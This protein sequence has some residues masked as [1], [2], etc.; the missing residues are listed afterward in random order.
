M[1]IEV[2]ADLFAFFNELPDSIHNRKHYLILPFEL[3]IHV[4]SS[5]ASSVVPADH[6]VDIHHWDY[7]HNGF[8]A[9]IECR[10]M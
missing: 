6:A 4:A 7:F 10:G 5:N 3:P 9:E 2:A 1:E 8:R